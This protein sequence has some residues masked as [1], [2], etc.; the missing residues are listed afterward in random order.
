MSDETK[1]L[2]PCKGCGREAEINEQTICCTV[3]WYVVCGPDLVES[4]R[5]WRAAMAPEPEQEVA[6]LRKWQARAANV[7][8]GGLISWAP[9]A[10]AEVAALLSEVPA[11]GEELE[12]ERGFTGRLPTLAAEEEDE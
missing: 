12:E 3:C 2:P 11:G 8:R 5:M 10:D 9:T 1:P 4:H 6:R 7:L